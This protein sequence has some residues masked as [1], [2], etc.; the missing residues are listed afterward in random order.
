MLLAFQLINSTVKL[1]VTLINYFLFFNAF[2]FGKSVIEPSKAAKN[3]APQTGEVQVSFSLQLRFCT[4]KT[5]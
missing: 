1:K 4:I 2:A 5:S 3:K